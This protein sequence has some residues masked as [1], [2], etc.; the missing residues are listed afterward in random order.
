[1]SNATIQDMEMALRGALAS[2]APDAMLE[3]KRMFGGAGFYAY[4]QIFAA[5]FGK[6]LALKLPEASR[7][8]LLEIEGTS[9]SQSPQYI[10]VPDT[11]LENLSL[12]E[13][14]VSQSVNYIRSNTHS[15]KKRS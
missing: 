11:F 8:R 1:M 4:G 12:L 7:K 15:K 3:W 10:Q 6:G 2:V 9:V 5:S 14:W 13:S